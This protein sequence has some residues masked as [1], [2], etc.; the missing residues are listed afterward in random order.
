MLV[1]RIS[2]FNFTLL[3][4]K[5]LHVLGSRNALKQDFLNLIGLVKSGDVAL[6]KVI[7][8][9]YKFDEAA[10]AF[11]EFSSRGNEMLK[12]MINFEA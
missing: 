8:N 11:S 7:T 1:K 4:K 3:Q 6:E 12:V 5:E 9:T 2:D 10:K